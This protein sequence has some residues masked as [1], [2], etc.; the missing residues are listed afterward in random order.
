MARHSACYA[1]KRKTRPTSRRSS[2]FS[3]V[4]CRRPTLRI[5]SRSLGQVVHMGGNGTGVIGR[6]R[7]ALDDFLKSQV[8]ESLVRKAQARSE[9]DKTIQ[10]TEA[11]LKRFAARAFCQADVERGAHD[12]VFST[13][14]IKLM[15]EKLGGHRSDF[16]GRVTEASELCRSS[17]KTL[18]RA[19]SPPRRCPTCPSARRRLGSYLDRW[20]HTS[21]QFR[22]AFR[23]YVVGCRLM[24]SFGI[25]F[26]RLSKTIAVVLEV[27]TWLCPGLSCSS[28]RERKH[29]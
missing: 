21:Q 5:V 13:C 11:G 14:S 12:D 6:S 20:A 19:S 10:E 22:E 9:F 23:F 16:W 28:N 3:P 8:N 24:L 4:A 1:R 2:P 26:E 15:C 7:S 18:R 29:S 25:L 27:V 17:M